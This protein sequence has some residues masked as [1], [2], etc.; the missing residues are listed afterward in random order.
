MKKKAAVILCTAA[1]F[2]CASC[3]TTETQPAVS[4]TTELT[5][6]LPSAGSY[7]D[8]PKVQ[9]AVN[10]I[11]HSSYPSHSINFKFINLYEYSKTMSV[12][13]AA[14]EQADII[15]ANDNVLPYINYPSTSTYKFLNAPISSYAPN[16]KSRL[17][18]DTVTLSRIYDKNYFIPT[19]RHSKGLIPF[20]KIPCTLID[21]FDYE[22]FL[23]VVSSSDHACQ[24]LF[25]VID[26]YLL[27]LQKNNLIA[28]GVDFSAVS[29]IFPQI[30]YETFISTSNLIGYNICDPS[31]TAVD[32]INEPSTK[33]S[34]SVYNDWYNK[35]YIK[36]DISI[37]YKS[38][39][40]SE[41]D[42]VLSGAWGYEKD[43]VFSMIMDKTTSGYIYIAADNNYHIDKQ[44]SDSVLIIPTASRNFE[45]ALKILDLFYTDQRLYNLV[46]FGIENEHYM[47][48]ENTVT[49]LSD[50]YRCFENIVPQTNE[51]LST[52]SPENVMLPEMQECSESAGMFIPSS[53]T[54]FRRMLFEYTDAFSVAPYSTTLPDNSVS[55]IDVLLKIYNSDSN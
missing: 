22:T 27:I 19:T 1:L 26:D 48:S 52:V 45:Y 50:N 23:N 5:W 3:S 11:I 40:D 9:T 43:G 12:Y 2:F 4:N 38:G 41:Y 7:I 47:V 24:D 14:G 10:E 42:Y 25:N 33:L 28:N 30:G 15:W 20:I 49:L 53:D 21:Y 34:Y 44:F 35:A 32:I 31:H 46:T 29:D 13:L 39:F 6:F 54:E 36:N 18:E 55:Q 8:T 37:I 51:S 16:I 17:D